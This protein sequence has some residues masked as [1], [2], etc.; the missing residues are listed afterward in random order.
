MFVNQA[1]EVVPNFKR[2]KGSE[3]EHTGSGSTYP[4]S[5]DPELKKIQA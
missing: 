4:N 5:N 1:Q 2:G 3:E